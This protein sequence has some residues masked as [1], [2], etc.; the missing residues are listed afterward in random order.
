MDF[1]STTDALFARLDHDDLAKALGVSIASIRQARL[2]DG[3]AAHRRPPNGWQEV[4][5]KL[6]EERH[7]HYGKLVDQLKSIKQPHSDKQ[8]GHPMSTPSPSR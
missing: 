4:I 2:R 8:R 5:L 3:A 1:R 6:A 7:S